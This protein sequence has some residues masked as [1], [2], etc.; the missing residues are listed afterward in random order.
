MCAAPSPFTT[1]FGYKW[2]MIYEFTSTRLAL[3]VCRLTCWPRGLRSTWRER[4][5]DEGGDGRLRSGGRNCMVSFY[6]QRCNGNRIRFRRSR[7]SPKTNSSSP[8]VD[9]F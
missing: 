6:D 1:Y 8:T 3:M 5:S 7:A 2:I 4:E 9:L